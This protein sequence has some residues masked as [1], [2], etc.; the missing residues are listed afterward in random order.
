M[1][2]KSVGLKIT[3]AN[4]CEGHLFDECGQLRQEVAGRLNRQIAHQPLRPGIG[5]HHLAAQR[6]GQGT[7]QCGHQL[8]TQAWHHPA[9]VDWAG[10]VEVAFGNEHTDA[11]VVLSGRVR[12]AQ[13]HPHPS[14]LP[15]R[16]EQRLVALAALGFRRIGQIEQAR[17]TADGIA[18]PALETAQIGDR[19]GNALQEPFEL[20]GFVKIVPSAL[21]VRDGI[22]AAQRGVVL[23]HK[24]GQAAAK[25]LGVPFAQHQSVPNEELA[26]Q[27]RVKA[28]QLPPSTGHEHH[29]IQAGFLGHHGGAEPAVPARLA[30]RAL[31]QL[32]AGS[33]RPRGV[34]AGHRAGIEPGGFDE[35]G[36]HYQ[37]RWLAAQIRSGREHEAAPAR[38]GVFHDRLRLR[39]GRSVRLKLHA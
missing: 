30:E 11:V 1:G 21:P 22:P 8:G 16:R 3:R 39:L 19:L 24:R 6:L 26:G 23:A 15:N 25:P 4:R 18:P 12:V 20:A 10:S 34:D 32:A 5:R 36:R 33:D 37:R 27:L 7:Q 9:E 17:L 38:A 2:G 13:F 35:L 28:G 31:T 29:A 14:G